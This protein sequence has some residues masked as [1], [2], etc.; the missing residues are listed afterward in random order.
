[1]RAR[2]L[3]PLPLVL[4][5]YACEDSSTPPEGIAPTFDAGQGGFDAGPLPDGA[6][7]DAFAPDATDGPAPPKGISVTVRRG[8]SP[9]ADVRVL[10]HDAAGAITAELKTD[11]AGKVTAATAPSMVTIL[12]EPGALLRKG[13]PAGALT[14]LG[15]ADGDQLVVQVPELLTEP[16]PVGTYSVTTQ[17]NFEGGVSY[18]LT[19]RGR[20]SAYGNDATNP[21]SI[22]LYGHCIGQTVAVLAT[23]YGEGGDIVAFAF[24]KGN[25]PPA[26]NQTANV[27]LPAW[28]APGSLLLTASNVPAQLA[29]AVEDVTSIADGAPFYMGTGS[30]S[31][32]D[33]GVT[34]PV[35]TGFA[36]AYQAAVVA[37]T[38]AIGTR[39]MTGFVR[40]AAPA[41]SIAFDFAQALPL[42]TGATVTPGSPGRPDVAWTTAA[43]I[44]SDGGLVTL[45]WTVTDGE[46]T[47]SRA[48]RFVVPPGTSSFKVPA[49]P[50]EDA[51]L[52]A[53]TLGADAAVASVEQLES[54]LLPSYAALKALPLPTDADLEGVHVYAPLPAN[55]NLRV[56]SWSPN[57]SPR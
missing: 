24:K 12:S 35:P 28:A 27:A 19:A 31:L 53:F 30:G 48:W 32:D 43:P 57:L 25:A 4:L 46:T 15:V 41:A 6:V 5:V 13:P 38:T 7:P 50:P 21:F 23:A 10:L 51:G 20:C 2:W 55:G 3:T 54:E 8:P 56:T 14:Y 33:G 26:L 39:G 11:A 42:V 9:Q 1:M 16:L 52:P 37:R 40:R 47:R 49:L 29:A 36:E 22:A 17:G 34:V 18:E 45:G 44:A